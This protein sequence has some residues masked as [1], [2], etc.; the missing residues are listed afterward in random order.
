VI[1]FDEGV[2]VLNI[3]MANITK[4]TTLITTQFI[5]RHSFENGSYNQTTPAESTGFPVASSFTYGLPIIS[6][7]RY[8]QIIF[9]A[10]SFD[11]SDWNALEGS[12]KVHTFVSYLGVGV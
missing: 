6:G 8:L 3:P 1:T 10:A 4:D 5:I 2:A 9:K 7:V 11:G 12:H